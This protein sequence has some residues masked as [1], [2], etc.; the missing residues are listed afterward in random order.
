MW[1]SELRTQCSLCEGAGLI[2]GIA[3]WV[4]DQVVYVTDVAQILT[5]V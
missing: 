4:K 5:V 3:Q 2:P 1:L